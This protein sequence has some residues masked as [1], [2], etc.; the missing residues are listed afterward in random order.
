MNLVEMIENETNKYAKQF[1]ELLLKEGYN[2]AD[3]DKYEKA[4]TKV[5][6]ICDKG[7]EYITTPS[8][9]K[10]GYRC[11]TCKGGITFD[12]GYFEKYVSEVSNGEYTILEKYSNNHTPIT[13]RHN[14]LSC[15]NYEWKVIPSDFRNKGS[16]CPICSI[17]R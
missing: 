13:I 5:K 8:S 1:Y 3:G 15:D 14:N 9:F 4:K 10:S 11:G 17:L 16:R 7:H 6:F 2:L 12:E